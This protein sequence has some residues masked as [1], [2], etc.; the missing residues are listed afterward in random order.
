[1]RQDK[2]QG[3]LGIASRAVRSVTRHPMRSALLVGIV[4]LCSCL[5]LSSFATLSASVRTQSDGSEA[6]SGSYRVELDVGNLRKRMAELPPEYSHVDE[7]GNWWTELPDNAFESVLLA[8]MEKLG[9]AEGVS[10]WSMVS[11]PV[12]A[13]IPDSQRIEDPDRDQTYDY[14]GVNVVGARDVSMEQNVVAG[15]VAISEGRWPEVGDEHVVAISEELARLNGLSVG[16]IIRFADAK[17]PEGGS[18]VTARIC[19]V[20]EIVHD[21]PSTMSGD[22]YRSENTV[23]SDLDLSQ[24]IAGRLDDPL[25]SYATFSV[26]DPS[27]YREVGEAL[28]GTDIDW[29]RYQLVDDSGATERMADNFAGMERSTWVFMAFVAGCGIVL[30]ALSMAF[31]VKTRRREAGVLLSLGNGTTSVVGQ[32]VAEAIALALAG[33][34]VGCS[35][36]WPVSGAVAD[37]MAGRQAQIEQ[38]SEQASAGQI[39][40]AGDYS[41]GEYSGIE[42]LPSFGTACGVSVACTATVAMASALAIAPA[43]I[44]GPRRLFDEVE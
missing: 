38:L 4:A 27:K 18:I 11:V 34:L 15:N 28:K 6:A 12:P 30:V 42:A 36:A 19:G 33:C 13:S 17:D 24:E 32:V 29:A 7:S 41:E 14:G 16:D 5:L 40:G 3:R 9:E 22:T 10:A 43:A 8:D 25:Y 1:M 2:G 23:F 31:W 26:A 21:I 20:F 37:S 35:L 44:R 39:A